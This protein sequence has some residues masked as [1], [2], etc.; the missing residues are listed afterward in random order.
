MEHF[1]V[2]MFLLKLLGE[3]SLLDI[4]FLLLKYCDKNNG[5]LYGFTVDVLF[6]QM[7]AEKK[8]REIVM[9]LAPKQKD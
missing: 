5:K 6:L 3:N 9:L 1:K 4:F 8:K 2:S 7:S